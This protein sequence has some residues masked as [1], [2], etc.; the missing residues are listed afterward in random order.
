MRGGRG[1]VR[2][3]LALIPIIYVNSFAVVHVNSFAVVLML[4]SGFGISAISSVPYAFNQVLPDISLG[5]WTYL[6]Q[7]LLVC[8]LFGVRRNIHIP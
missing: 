6:F 3:E 8:I 2:K 1:R 4:F 5:T 7:G